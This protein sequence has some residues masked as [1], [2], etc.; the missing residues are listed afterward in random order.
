MSVE[1]FEPGVR[2][3]L[4]Q[5]E[6]HVERWTHR[7]PYLMLFSVAAIP[8]GILWNGQAAAVT[9]GA[10]IVCVG[11]VALATDHLYKRVRRLRAHLLE[12]APVTAS[13]GPDPKT[14][15]LSA[16]QRRER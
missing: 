12:P 15:L 14:C 3:R 1:H 7:L 10:T 6:Q 13:N 8:V 5:R 16:A 4:L 9:V 2:G 11:T